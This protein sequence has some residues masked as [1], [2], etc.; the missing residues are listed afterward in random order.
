MGCVHD[1]SKHSDGLRV[2]IGLNSVA[3]S[4]AVIVRVYEDRERV[5]GDYRVLVDRLWPRGIRKEAADLDLWAKNIAPSPEL[6]K[7]YGHDVARF[8]E[9]KQLYAAELNAST[10]ENLLDELIRK[11]G[12]GQL[13]LLTATRD[14]EHS[15][16]T[17][18][19]SI[20]VG[21]LDS[22]SQT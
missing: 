1:E 12:S 5:P 18:L 15:A 6:R 14:V 22:N 7:W 11:A 2:L 4:R 13:L 19:Q 21:K 8:E 20:I 16:A 9:F 17:V 3:L 10:K